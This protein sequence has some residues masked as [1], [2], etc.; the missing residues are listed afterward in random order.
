MIPTLDYLPIG[1]AGVETFIFGA[2]A[3]PGAPVVFAEHGRGGAA[4]QMFACCR[5]L[6]TC[7]F[8]AVAI[9]QRNHGRRIVDPLANGGWSPQHAADMYGACVG[10]AM[11]VSLLIDMLPARLGISTERVG[12]T[13]ISM[14][15]HATLLAMAY[16]VR[17][18]VGAPVIG[19]GD[20]RHLMEMRATN[21]G[22]AAE[23]FD[24]F[25]PPA[26]QR[27]V[28]KFDPIH[29]PA[30]FADRPLL[31][32]NGG[33]DTLVPAECNQ[34]FAAACRPHYR[35]PERLQTSLYP[36]VGHEFPPAMWQ[37]VQHWLQRWLK[38]PEA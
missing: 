15:G 28:E 24:D 13:G 38:T 34:R 9:D 33:A 11:D 17:I 36:G 14:G 18:A 23:Q 25:F 32:I 10:T 12:M 7:G 26:L 2:E 4:A 6:V 29:H 1:I 27:A 5:D 8:I 30:R 37:E 16:D 19:S 31:L 22:V 35:Q 20:Y 3:N 21:N